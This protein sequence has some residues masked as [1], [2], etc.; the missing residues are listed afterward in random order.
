[1]T[2]FHFVYGVNGP[3]GGRPRR[4]RRRRRKRRELATR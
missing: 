1:M 2:S 4:R 3:T